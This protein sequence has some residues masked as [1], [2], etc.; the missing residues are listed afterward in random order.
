MFKLVRDSTNFWI[1]FS[2]VFN[3]RYS[4]WI[5]CAYAKFLHAQADIFPC[6]TNTKMENP[7]FED[8]FPV[9]KWGFSNVTF[10][11]RGLVLEVLTLGT[12]NWKRFGPSGLWQQQPGWRTII[13]FVG[14]VDDLACFLLRFIMILM[15]FYSEIVFFIQKFCFLFRNCVFFFNSLMR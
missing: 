1:S 7:P 9:W 4:N 13:W 3:W 6:K 14:A 5:H 15:I 2:S 12:P 11:F 8:A 10:V